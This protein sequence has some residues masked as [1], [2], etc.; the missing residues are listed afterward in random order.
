MKTLYISDLDGTLLGSDGTLSA[1]TH[2]ALNSMLGQGLLFSAPTA[3]SPV[4]AMP[5]LSGLNVYA[6]TTQNCVRRNSGSST[7]CAARCSRA[8]FIIWTR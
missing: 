5:L 4:S 3:R 1:Y 2:G 8:V 7:G 6:I